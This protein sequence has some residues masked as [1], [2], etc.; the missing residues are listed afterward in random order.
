MIENGGKQFRRGEWQTWPT[1]KS[2]AEV[3]RLLWHID[4]SQKS[5]LLVVS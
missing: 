1:S 2:A 4:R 3:E 5:L